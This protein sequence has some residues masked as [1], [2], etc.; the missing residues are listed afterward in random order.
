MVAEKKIRSD[1]LFFVFIAIIII[2]DQLSKLLIRSK[3][4][5]NQSRNVISNFLSISYI[6]NTGAGFGILQGLNTFL[7][8]V[9]I[10][11][12]V[13]LVYY[14]H[15]KHKNEVIPRTFFVLILGGAISNLIDRFAYGFVV[16]FIDFTFWPAFNIADTS[17]TIG[18]IGLI[19]FYI[20]K[21]E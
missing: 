7:I 3:F 1:I 2:A 5:P 16:D 17:I 18:T 11:I 20:K 10:I 12:I 9:T 4:L 8:V 6:Q 19:L 21:N 13:L 15:K 14:Y